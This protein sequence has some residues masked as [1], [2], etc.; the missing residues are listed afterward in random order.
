M[1]KVCSP[2]TDA[3]PRSFMT[4]NFRTTEFRSVTC[5]SQNRPSATVNTG[6]SRISAVAVLADQEGRRLPAGQVQRQP[7]D[8]A[9]H[10]HLR[11]SSAPCRTTVRK[12][13]TTTTAG[14]GRF[15]FA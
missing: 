11:P 8:E 4:C 10:V 6:L 9:L 7:L 15:H 5:D 3:W 12:E 1:R 13:S 2:G 14:L